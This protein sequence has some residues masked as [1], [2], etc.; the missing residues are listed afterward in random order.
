[1][2]DMVL[3]GTRLRKRVHALSWFLP[4]VFSLMAVF[5]QLGP[6][7]WVHDRYSHEI[8]YL[9][10]IV[11]YASAGPLLTFLTMRRLVRWLDEKERAENQ[12]RT[13]E[14]RLASITS[15]SADAI[16][17]LDGLGHIESWNDGAEL[18]FGYPAHEIMG[19]S[20]LDLFG[21]SEAAEV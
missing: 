16:L 11:F 17:S 6:A 5:Y 19:R 3:T 1:M 9:V 21:G 18:I 8:H 14:Q 15:A 13:S 7:R 2:V 12:A 20:F 4:I 10:E